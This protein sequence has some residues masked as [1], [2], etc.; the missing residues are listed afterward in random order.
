[1]MFI[2]QHAH[3]RAAIC[4]DSGADVHFATAIGRCR[5]R[6]FLPA[7]K[8]REAKCI[9]H[10]AKLDAEAPLDAKEVKNLDI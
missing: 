8:K 6:P 3:N 2:E 5:L 9:R 7:G 1:M 4:A 10:R